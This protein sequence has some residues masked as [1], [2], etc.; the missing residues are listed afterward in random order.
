MALRLSMLACVVALTRGALCAQVTL[1]DDLGR[2]V[3]LPETPR[4]IVSL[5]PSITET[6]FAIG[7]GGQ[8]A[9]VTDYCNYPEEAAR[10]PR[11]GGIINPS[12]ETIVGLRSDLI[13]LSMVGNVREDFGKLTEFGSPVFVT[14]PGTLEGIYKSVTDL[15]RLTGHQQRA[16]EVIHS[17][18]STGRSIAAMMRPQIQPRAMVIVSIQPLIV[19]GKDTYI[20]ELLERA[21]A[22]N[23][24]DSSPASY[25]TYSREAVVKENPDVIIVTSDL[26]ADTDALLALFP[27]WRI[28]KAAQS[29]R[30]HRIDADLVSRPGPRAAEALLALHRL[31]H[32]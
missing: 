27:E 17:M 6:L 23:I 4:R 18:R 10:K 20:N 24:V 30:I 11:V 16:E 3:A 1:T 9:G 22:T 14:N 13:I 25:P 5:A 31:I 29:R 32:Q 12:I 21:G 7:A 8:I 19:A 26:I 2:P 28:V 15:G